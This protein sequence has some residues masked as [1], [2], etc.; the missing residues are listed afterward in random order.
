V[1]SETVDLIGDIGQRLDVVE[2]DLAELKEMARG[3]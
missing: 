3:Y 2:S 1:G